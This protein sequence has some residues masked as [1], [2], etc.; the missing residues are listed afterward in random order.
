[1]FTSQE[2]GA[3]QPMKILVARNPEWSG[4]QIPDL[5]KEMA[6]KVVL[7]TNKGTTLGKEMAQKE[8]EKVVSDQIT[9]SAILESVRNR[10]LRSVLLDLRGSF[11]N[12]QELLREGI[13]QNLLQKIVVEV[14]PWWGGD[15]DGNLQ[16]TL[17]ELR[18]RL[19]L[20]N[21][22]SKISHQSVVIEGYVQ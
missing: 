2:L 6:S 14:L 3:N 21:L 13:E 12:L 10:G 16:M 11:S 20:K 8:I 22:Q 18:K 19:K 9:L 17:K 4:I 5:T 7:F 15:Y 1:M